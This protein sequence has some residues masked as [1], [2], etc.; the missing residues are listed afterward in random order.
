MVAG[1]MDS[2]I[3]KMHNRERVYQF[4]CE[5]GTV[6]KQDIVTGLRLSLPT[7]TQNLNYLNGQGLIDTSSQ[8]KKT[9]GRNA[10]AYSIKAGARYAIGVSLTGHHLNA[11]SVNLMGEVGTVL[12]HRVPFDLESDA[13]LQQVAQLIEEVI[14]KDQIEREGLLGVGISVPGL[15]SEDGEEVIYGLTLRFTGKK[16]ADITKYIPYPTRLFHDAYT[17][18]YAEMRANPNLSRAFYVSLGNSVGGSIIENGSIYVGYSGTAGEVGHMIVNPHSKKRCYCGNYGC[19]DTVCSATVLDSYTDGNLAEFFRLKREGDREAIKLWD[20]YL[21]NLVIA[22]HNICMLLDIKIVLGG[23]V[24]A[25][26]TEDFP[27]LYRRLD[28][29]NPFGEKTENYL[30]PCMSQV[31]CIAV[32]SARVFIDEYLGQILQE[33]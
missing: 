23:Y 15:V 7:V 25:Y 20:Q 1:K 10:T 14:E 19:F 6:S 18:G 3:I 4:I 13:Y 5:K 32:G 22:I 12:R 21:D 29:L 2:T 27:E 17:A 26:L 30:I 8:I 11:L 28:K 24:G 9:G 16:K 33:P 31:E